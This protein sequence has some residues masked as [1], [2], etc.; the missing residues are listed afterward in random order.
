MKRLI[1]TSTLLLAAC[2]GSPGPGVI[3]QDRIVRSEKP[4]VVPCATK[5]PAKPSTLKDDFPDEIWFSMDV[6]QRAAAVS[7]K[8]L[9]LLNYADRLAAATGACPEVEE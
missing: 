3:V 7:A 1:I 8:G 2:A 6:K 5:L 9:E 4:V